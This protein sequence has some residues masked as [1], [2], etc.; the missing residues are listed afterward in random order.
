[1]ISFKQF[2][3]EEFDWQYSTKD[4][5]WIKAQ[6]KEKGYTLLGTGADKAA[7]IDSSHNII[8]L[9][10]PVNGTG[11]AKRRGKLFLEWAK[12]CQSKK[13]NP[14]LPDIIDF[15]KFDVPESGTQFIQVKMEKLFPVKKNLGPEVEYMLN[16]IDKLA[17]KARN[18]TQKFQELLDKFIQ[19]GYGWDEIDVSKA[20]GKVLLHISDFKL[21]AKTLFDVINMGK[22]KGY[23]IDLHDANYMLSSDGELVIVDP[24][25]TGG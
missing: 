11:E 21:F 1:M 5:K 24:W 18:N 19:N 10:G 9:V 8:V 12:Y 20:A 17:Q 3:S 7:F 15:T 16:S 23:Q 13:N 22:S 14:Y 4:T 6:M 25:Y 2:L